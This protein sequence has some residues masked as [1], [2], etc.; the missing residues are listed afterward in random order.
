MKRG[1]FQIADE[2]HNAEHRDKPVAANW[3]AVVPALLSTALCCAVCVIV[4]LLMR[5]G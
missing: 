1:T 3:A 5:A 4:Y 2:S